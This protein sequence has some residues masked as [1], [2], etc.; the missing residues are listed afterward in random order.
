M[1]D[2][3]DRAGRLGAPLLSAVSLTDAERREAVREAEVLARLAESADETD[4]LAA[5]EVLGRTSRNLRR[6]A[7]GFSEPTPASGAGAEALHRLAYVSRIVGPNRRQRL[8][9]ASSIA[10]ASERRNSA[11]GITGALS[12][13]GGWYAQVLEGPAPAVIATFDRILCDRRHTD[14]RLLDFSPICARAFANWSMAF[15]GEVAPALLQRARLGYA[16]QERLA[17]GTTTAEAAAL[18][19]AMGE[20]LEGARA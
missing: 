6:L 2:E 19:A 17:R 4:L 5:A 12:V 7:A 9:A 13:G 3:H 18:W 14:I 10:R 1:Q 16:R 20:R 11:A 8:D 15:C